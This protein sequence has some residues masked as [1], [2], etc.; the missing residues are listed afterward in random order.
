[1][2]APPA[3]GGVKAQSQEIGHL[4]ALVEQQQEAIKN[5]QVLVVLLGNQ[6]PQHHAQND[7]MLEEIFNLILGTVNTSEALQW[8]YITQ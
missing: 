1:M 2:H 8:P 7:A 6:E 3:G 5:Y 4:S